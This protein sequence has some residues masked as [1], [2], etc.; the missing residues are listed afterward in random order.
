MSTLLY[1][2]HA[3]QNLYPKKVSL[4]L[5]NLRGSNQYIGNLG[6]DIRPNEK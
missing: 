1:I 6:F 2:F 3:H 4:N 5:S